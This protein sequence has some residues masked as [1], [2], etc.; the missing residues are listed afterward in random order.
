MGMNH[1]KPDDLEKLVKV[2]EEGHCPCRAA[3][4]LGISKPHY[5][6]MN[7]LK[8]VMPPE[9]YQK[10]YRKRQQLPP[11]LRKAIDRCNVDRL[12]K[13]VGDLDVNLNHSIKNITYEELE[14]LESHTQEL[15]LKIGVLKK[16]IKELNEE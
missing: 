7:I 2:F 5:N 3:E 13:N 14:L 9:R 10:A 4:S 6:M 11:Y 1:I 8:E 12:F 16:G 15:S